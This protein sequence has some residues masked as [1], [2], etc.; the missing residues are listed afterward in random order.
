MKRTASEPGLIKHHSSSNWSFFP[1]LHKAK[2]K[3]RKKERNNLTSDIF[4][5]WQNT[6]F[7]R[8]A[9]NRHSFLQRTQ[10]YFFFIKHSA[11]KMLSVGWT[12]KPW[13]M[14]PRLTAKMKQTF[15]SYVSYYHQVS[16]RLRHGLGKGTKINNREKLRSVHY[17][18]YT[19]QHDYARGVV[20]TTN[21]ARHIGHYIPS[22]C[23]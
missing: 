20:F 19:N 7:A 17:I 14:E 6:A 23:P 2:K 10:K 3:Q 8:N 15:Y 21:V 9:C 12:Y 4:P 22:I 11:R 18:C 16:Q 1:Q 13:T 5:E